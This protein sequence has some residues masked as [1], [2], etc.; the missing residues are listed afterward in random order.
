MKLNKQT[1]TLPYLKA[2][3]CCLAAIWILF[4]YW[5]WLS[6]PYHSV[7][8][9]RFIDTN[10]KML[11]SFET[12]IYFYENLINSL[13]LIIQSGTFLLLTYGF[14]RYALLKFFKNT[15]EKLEIFIFSSALGFGIIG[16]MT[17]I[18]AACQI[19]Y[20][21]CIFVILIPGIFLLNKSI[22]IHPIRLE[23][24]R[25]FLSDE[26]SEFEKLLYFITIVLCI[27]CLLSAFTPDAVEVDTLN[28]YLAVPQWWLFN[29][30]I[31]DMPQHIYHNLFSLYGCVYAAVMGFTNE[32]VPKLV[33]LYA[34]M[35]G[36]VAMLIYFCS[37]YFS[38]K[39]LPIA[40]VIMCG[41]YQ[42]CQM[43][44]H[45]G[46]DSFCALFSLSALAAIMLHTQGNKKTLALSAL[47]SGF[48]MASKPTSLLIIAP[49]MGI[50]L[51][52][53]RSNIRKS[54]KELCIFVI[55][56][57]MP[58]IPWLIKNYVLRGNPF[59]PF[60][61]NILGTD[62][63]YDP[64]MIYFF[65][66][67][68]YIYSGV[69]YGFFKNFWN[70]FFSNDMPF[71]YRTSPFLLATAVFIPFIFRKGDK[72]IQI[73]LCFTIVS[74]FLHL[75]S[76]STTRYYFSLYLFISV[77][78]AYYL[79][80]VLNKKIL[81]ITFSILIIIPMLT[82]FSEFISYGYRNMILGL[83]N[84]HQ[85]LEMQSYLSAVLWINKNLPMSSK[86]LIDEIWGRGFYMQREYYTTSFYDNDWYDIFVSE[87]D[88]PED[89][90]LSLKKKGI[91]H[92][93][94]NIDGIDH[95][96]KL[97]IYRENK[98]SNTK[99]ENI[100]AFKNKYLLPIYQSN[101]FSQS[102]VYKILY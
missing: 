83:Q 35:T 23:L 17:F 68:S 32:F 92:I 82:S 12:G 59:F 87:N 98:K 29:H 1:V 67:S 43:S 4:I 26:P 62:K 28:Y 93:L 89:I 99:K 40:L 81:H 3:L 45:T 86:I 72:K 33:N 50:I 46:S 37:K 85:Y 64:M 42:F 34:A 60:L 57:S 65:K 16:G 58:V 61:T 11:F 102:T 18:L 88:S 49:A 69:R 53:G 13:I 94:S 8:I 90:L 73:L 78:F 48:A 15:Y 47:L 22:E 75:L 39:I 56:A 55:I 41:T 51:Y 20:P 79:Y 74:L 44:F 101:Y 30:G 71:N 91:T 5:Y 14:G 24:F 76:V 31:K 10:W 97:E 95:S 2:V 70:I 6:I 80:P 77:F 21:A 7:K 52:N 96:E 19:L 54:L 84:R 36:T 9:L 63:A 100:N 27:L 66:E 38:R 25:T